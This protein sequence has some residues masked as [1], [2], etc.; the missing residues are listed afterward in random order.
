MGGYS[1]EIKNIGPFKETKFSDD[2]I[3][4]VI[5]ADN[6]EGKTF[7]SRCFEYAKGEKVNEI[8]YSNNLIKQGETK[9]SFD[10]NKEG[11]HSKFIIEKNK[12]SNLSNESDTIFYVFNSDYVKENVE[13]QNYMPDGSITGAVLVK[14]EI[15]LTNEKTKLNELKNKIENKKNA[16]DNKIDDKKK[17]L[18]D[19]GISS[20]M[21]AYKDINFENI[22]LVVNIAEENY[23]EKKADL[24]LLESI[25]DDLTDVTMLQRLNVDGWNGGIL[26]LLSLILKPSNLE[27]EFCDYVK[28]NLKFIETGMYLTNENKEA[29][30]PFCKRPFDDDSRKLIHQYSEFLENKETSTI[31]EIDSKINNLSSDIT[32]ILNL[33]NS[34]QKLINETNEISK[35]FKQAQL[36]NPKK[37]LEMLSN[38]KKDLINSQQK[39]NKKKENLATEIAFDLTEENYNAYLTSINNEIDSINEV[40][41]SLNKIKND[42]ANY[43]R[44]LREDV[45]NEAKK[46]LS[47]ELIGDI[48]EY[49]NLVNESNNLKNEIREK[50]LTGSLEKR[51]LVANSIEH[52]IKE[53]FHDKYK[54]NRETF[55]LSLNGINVEDNRFILSE[56]EKSVVAFIVYISNLYRVVNTADEYQK[57]IFIIDDPI[58]SL[59]FNYVY[60]IS[61]VI[62][63]LKNKL[64]IKFS[65]Q[66][67]LTHNLEFFN[68]L[69]RNG[70]QFNFWILKNGNF[71]RMKLDMLLPYEA[72]L[73]DI[74]KISLGKLEPSHT[75]P[76]S[77]RHIIETV[78][79]FEGYGRDINK[80]MADNDEFKDNEYI[81]TLINDLSHGGYRDEKPYI[82][83]QVLEACKCVIK[84]IQN[85]YPLQL[86]FE[87]I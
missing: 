35:Y 14:N 28:N 7:I 61:S 44:N 42:S 4:T 74:N 63:Q 27:N 2:K 9:G 54:F 86:A 3:S 67:V 80:F 57:I 85:H 41:S 32:K 69:K 52:Y 11:K 55:E 36:P 83:N 37:L 82:D 43:R 39:L 33:E 1:F 68:I 30:C 45:C 23:V 53:F 46:S 59:D 19:I 66:I 6:G 48:S 17:E 51:T 34:V 84:Y 16:I 70:N 50:E 72:H 29:T 5:F 10:F 15:D 75:T 25:P 38:L 62:K 87:D 77:L 60:E 78:A 12:R 20:S 47:N 21:K 73:E 81:L 31:K 24:K 8:E 56:G 13:S 58:S 26:E 18:K 71:K 40:I 64:N 22:S 49:K 79:R 65:K 76:N